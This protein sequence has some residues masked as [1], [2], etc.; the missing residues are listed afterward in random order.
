MIKDV[1]GIVLKDRDYAESSKILEVFTRDLGIIG[2]ISKGSKKL[3][4][5]LGGVSSKLVY[6]TFHIYYKGD[7][8]STLTSADVKNPYINIRN[9]IVKLGFSTYLCELTYQ[10]VKQSGNSKELFDLVVAALNK[11]NDNYDPLVISN[12]L[13][14][15]YLDFLGVAP[16]LDKCY[17]C[18]SSTN[19]MTISPTSSGLVCKECF[20]NEKI[21]D[22]NVIKYLRMYQY[23][24]ISKI[25]KIDINSSI[26]NQINDFLNEYYSH[27]T[28]IYLN[29]KKF[30]DELKKL[31]L[32]N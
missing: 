26:K 24:D 5:N 17:S 8:L 29:A 28:G 20:E 18:G 4:S 15:K 32:Y 6:G 12:I 21:Y 13:E 31:N 23:L 27:H 22:L 7:K 19:I 9:D 2:I 16:I 30:L 1:L 3:K 10:V 14:L 11:I 25:S